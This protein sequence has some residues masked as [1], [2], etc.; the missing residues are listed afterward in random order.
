[1]KSHLIKQPVITEKSLDLA[2]QENVYTFLVAKPATKGQIKVA[3]EKLFSVKVVGL[4]TITHYLVK[5]RTGRK[6]MP[7]MRAPVKKA[8][9]KLKKGD[10]IKLFDIGGSDKSPQG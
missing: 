6:R 8:L 5:K 3:I 2:N 4:R 1:M 9:V 7:V 10:S